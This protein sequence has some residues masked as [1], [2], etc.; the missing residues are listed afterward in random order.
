MKTSHGGA[1]RGAGRKAKG[2]GPV[3]LWLT[4]QQ[5]QT[6]SSLGGS[7]WLQQKL[8]IIMSH[9]QNI[10]T[11][12]AEELA[13]NRFATK[14]ELL[15]AIDDALCDGEVLADHEGEWTQDDIEA[16][17]DLVR[18]MSEQTEAPEIFVIRTDNHHF[19]YA[20]GREEF[21]SSFE[22]EGDYAEWR[23]NGGTLDGV[24]DFTDRESAL[25]FID[26]QYEQEIIDK[27]D[28]AARRAEI[29]LA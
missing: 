6:L 5:H 26:D 3:K 19:V 9:A 1:R 23:A 20:Y 10:I 4:P 12:L 2:S 28:W 29:L 11:T 22:L 17:E 15:S 8:E 16:A 14:E 13:V 7:A 21:M 27:E 25:D 18:K 24:M